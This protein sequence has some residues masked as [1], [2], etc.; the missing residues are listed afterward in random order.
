VTVADETESRIL[1]KAKTVVPVA[2]Y[3]LLP[4]STGSRCTSTTRSST[5]STAMGHRLAHSDGLALVSAQEN[6]ACSGDTA[7][8]ARDRR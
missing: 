2:Q 8:V 7:P 4:H 3:S 1:D 5:T 6:A